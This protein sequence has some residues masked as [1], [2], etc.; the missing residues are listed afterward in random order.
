MESKDKKFHK[1][2][3]K[4][5]NAF[6]SIKNSITNGIFYWIKFKMELRWTIDP[7]IGMMYKEN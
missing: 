3:A 1:T 4:K 6:Y 7:A 5:L 2:V